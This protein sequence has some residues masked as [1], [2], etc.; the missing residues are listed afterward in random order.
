MVRCRHDTLNDVSVLPKIFKDFCS[1][2]GCGCII[3]FG[4]SNARD[5]QILLHRRW[6]LMCQFLKTQQKK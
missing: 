6:K 3:Y 1:K 4:L 5:I 2:I